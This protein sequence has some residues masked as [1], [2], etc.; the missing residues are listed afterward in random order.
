VET[1]VGLPVK[2]DGNPF[3]RS[4]A[5]SRVQAGGWAEESPPPRKDVNAPGKSVSALQRERER[6]ST[7]TVSKTSRL[8]LLKVV[9]RTK[10]CKHFLSPIRGACPVH[11]L[12]LGYM[13]FSCYFLQC[14]VLI[15][16]APFS[17]T[18]SLCPSRRVRN[19]V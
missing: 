1:R 4:T 16:S 14:Y 13:K 8:M 11:F 2:C 18:V 15:P 9:F 10:F 19:R 6:G 17:D 3:N 12:A 7:L 5:V